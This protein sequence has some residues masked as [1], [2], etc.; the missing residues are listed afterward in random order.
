MLVVARIGKAYIGQHDI[1][2]VEEADGR[3]RSTES[4]DS[5]LLES[6]LHALGSLK[7]RETNQMHVSVRDHEIHADFP[8]TIPSA[9]PSISR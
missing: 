8:A 4:D 2:Q 9:G 7:S 1:C 5:G 3:C 6:P